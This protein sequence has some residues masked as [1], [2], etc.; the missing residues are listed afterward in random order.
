MFS[1]PPASFFRGRLLL[2]SDI[3]A[4]DKKGYYYFNSLIKKILETCAGQS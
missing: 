4:N 3:F 2:F 1:V